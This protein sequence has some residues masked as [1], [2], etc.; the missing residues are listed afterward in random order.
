MNP[1]IDRIGTAIRI[2]KQADCSPNNPL[3]VLHASV[4]RDC[5]EHRS[6]LHDDTPRFDEDSGISSSGLAVM[7]SSVRMPPPARRSATTTWADANGLVIIR[8]L[9][10]PREAH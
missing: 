10:T 5:R 8:L 7:A 3:R 2:C 9:G 6:S 4:G 1:D